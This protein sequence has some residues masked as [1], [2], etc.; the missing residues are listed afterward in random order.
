MFSIFRQPLVQ[1]LLFGALFFVLY[2][3][4]PSHTT[5]DN[6][7]EVSQSALETYLQ[8]RTKQ[9]SAADAGERLSAM[10]ANERQQLINDYIRDEVLVREANKL[11]LAN[12][13]FVIRQRLIQKMGFLVSSAF[14]ITTPLSAQEIQAFYLQHQEHYAESAHYSFSHIFIASSQPWA[15]QTLAQLQPTL[16]AQE[17]IDESQWGEPFPY[18]RLYDNQD[19]TLITSHFGQAFTSQLASLKPSSLWQGPIQSKLGWHLV[20]LTSAT[21]ADDDPYSKNLNRIQRDAQAAHSKLMI[22]QAENALI[23]Q[24][25][26]VFDDR[27]IHTQVG[28]Q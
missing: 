2:Q 5:D 23:N 25:S 13:D 22:Q 20:H 4:L 26:I 11:G 1:F 19:A 18:Y 9:F 21:P 15:E 16:N 10:S 12:N 3:S 6:H 17:Q 14:A 28:Q 27:N 7:I 24:Y 8:Y